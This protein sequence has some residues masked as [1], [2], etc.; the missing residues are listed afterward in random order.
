[1]EKIIKELSKNLKEGSKEEKAIAIQKILFFD[2][3]QQVPLPF[4]KEHM[5]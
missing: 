4:I 1:M 3:N 5:E 2:Y